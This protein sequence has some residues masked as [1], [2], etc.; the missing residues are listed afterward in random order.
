MN[1][2]IP[3]RIISTPRTRNK[4]IYTADQQRLNSLRPRSTSSV[5]NGR[6]STSS[7]PGCAPTVAA[8]TDNNINQPTT[9]RS[10]DP[11]ATRPSLHSLWK[12]TLRLPC[13]HPVYPDR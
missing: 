11:V 8:A 6:C 9:S 1:D 5:D 12:N 10:D 3:A 13:N 2:D 7:P 4:S